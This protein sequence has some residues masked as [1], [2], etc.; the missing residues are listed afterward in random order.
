M[1]FPIE[2]EAVDC[3]LEGPLDRRFDFRTTPASGTSA[4]TSTIASSTAIGAAHTKITTGRKHRNWIGE[5]GAS[6][7]EWDA[8]RKKKK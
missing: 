5:K 7:L 6:L 1:T 2:D 3:R 4:G 8:K